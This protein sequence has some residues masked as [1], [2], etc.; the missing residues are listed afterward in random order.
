[1]QSFHVAAQKTID[2][3]NE[4]VNSLFWPDETKREAQRALNAALEETLRIESLFS[5]ETS[6]Q[7]P[8]AF[9]K[10]LYQDSE[11]KLLT[12]CRNTYGELQQ[13]YDGKQN[14][15]NSNT[16]LLIDTL[17]ELLDKRKSGQLE[18][19]GEQ[20]ARTIHEA[21][22]GKRL[23]AVQAERIAAERAGWGFD[24]VLQLIKGNKLG[25][26]LKLARIVTKEANLNSLIINKKELETILE[27]LRKNTSVVII[28][29]SNIDINGLESLLKEVVSERNEAKRRSERQRWCFS[30]ILDQ[31]KTNRTPP[32]LEIAKIRTEA[33]ASS[34]ATTLAPTI[35]KNEFQL[36]LEALKTNTSV[37]IVDFSNIDITGLEPL[38][39]TLASVRHGLTFTPVSIVEQLRQI[40]PA[41]KS[42]PL[43]T[44]EPRIS[45]SWKLSEHNLHRMQELNRG[46]YGIVHYG[47]LD[48]IDVAI[49]IPRGSDPTILEENKASLRHEAEMLEKFQNHP[50][51]VH[52][53]GICSNND[54]LSLVMEYMPKGSLYRVLHS[55]TEL[56]WTV[57]W[58]I[59]TEISKGIQALHEYNP[60][61]VHRDFKSPNILLNAQY[62]AKI[63][64]FGTVE[65]FDEKDLIQAENP[66]CTLAYRAP[67][68]QDPKKPAPHT[69]KADIYSLGVVLW[70]LASRDDPQSLTAQPSSGKPDVIPKGTPPH[71]AELIKGCWYT[72]P[73]K[74]PNIRE[75]VQTL[76]DHKAE[77]SLAPTQ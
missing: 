70:E 32:I 71:L 68:L 66:I 26:K 74:R 39:A 67:E 24:N 57:R 65:F 53:Y 3:V 27:A 56:N 19:A 54:S 2:Q 51:I 33:G 61:I 63:C 36:I 15:K 34:T 37:T 28:D 58:T 41:P 59:A 18:L 76:E 49:K 8:S 6:N 30:N 73:E 23:E 48:D 45:H 21:E 17:K 11:K 29:L 31:I 7:I 14:K 46:T 16:V 42:K 20:I 77:A 52:S 4:I 12:V 72:C 69:P 43:V 47:T 13:Y 64:D 9:Y 1:M 44:P 10:Y 40:P 5:G 55:T 22:E 75:V 50:N 38:I 25:P 62:H 35:N 60:C